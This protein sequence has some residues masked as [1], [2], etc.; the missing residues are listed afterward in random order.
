MS[1]LE[2]LEAIFFPNKCPFCDDIIKYDEIMCKNC[3]RKV[4]I[5]LHRRREVIDCGGRLQIFS[6]FL[7]KDPIKS[8]IYKLKFREKRNYGR[9]LGAIMA[10]TCRRGFFK[11]KIDYITSV[12]LHKKR[13]NERGYNQSKLLA[14]SVSKE[15]NVPY[16]EFLIKVKNNKIQHEIPFVM[17]KENVRGAY[18]AKRV[19][20]LKDKTILI[21]DDVVTTGSTMAEC[22]LTL[23]EAGAEKVLGLSL[24]I[25]PNG[26]DD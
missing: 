14:K 9:N 12:P 3:E 23:L 19:E 7:Y 1:K 20:N 2:R 8:A 13:L 15:I 26:N 16:A 22:A 11:D 6:P 10:M 18:K 5:S 4:E 21:C 25:V 24:A 17:R